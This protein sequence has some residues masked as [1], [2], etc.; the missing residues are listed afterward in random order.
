VEIEMASFLPDAYGIEATGDV[1]V[2]LDGREMMRTRQVAYPFPW[3]DE[4]IGHNPFGT[5]C[6][7]YFRGWIY[8]ARW[9]RE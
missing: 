3:G 5:T 4:R 8:D 7:A 9:M 6:A 1:V 2:R